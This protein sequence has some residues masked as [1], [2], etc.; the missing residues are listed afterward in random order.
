M[1]ISKLLA[2]LSAGVLIAACFFPWV[3]VDSKNVVIGGMHST[4]MQFGKPGMLHLILCGVYLLLL[5][6]HKPWSLRVA[7]FVAL[8]N[9]AWGLR[10]LILIPTCRGGIC[11]EKQPA[12]YAAF[13]ACI[14]MV[15][16]VL[17]IKVKG[18]LPAPQPAE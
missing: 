11:P 2:I 10:N 8:F 9:I 14:L 3:T 5:A 17:F 7:F 4:V 1:Q 16:S 18:K 6:F 13:I 15:V 12:L